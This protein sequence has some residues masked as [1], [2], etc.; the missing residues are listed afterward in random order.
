M[1]R[2]YPAAGAGSSSSAAGRRPHVQPL[3]T[4]I[5]AESSHDAN[6]FS[7]ASLAISFALLSDGRGDSYKADPRDIEIHVVRACQ[8]FVEKFAR[9]SFHLHALGAP[10]ATDADDPEHSLKNRLNRP[11]ML[12]VIESEVSYPAVHHAE[13]NLVV[14]IVTPLS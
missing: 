13:R 5:G 8:R 6:R 12:N 4:A 9:I 11:P 7:Q 14:P 3:A 10:S 2:S 1:N